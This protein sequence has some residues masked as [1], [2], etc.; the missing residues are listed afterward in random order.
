[1]RAAGFVEALLVAWPVIACIHN[2][3]NCAKTEHCI[4]RALSVQGAEPHRVG[5][6][7]P[8]FTR[9]LYRSASPGRGRSEGCACC[10]APS[11]PAWGGPVRPCTGAEWVCPPP[12]KIP[13]HDGADV[14]A[15]G[16]Y[17]P[18]SAASQ[19]PWKVLIELKTCAGFDE[20]QLA[21]TRDQGSCAHPGRG[22]GI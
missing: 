11:R 14:D 5:D 12:P 15:A 8:D 2:P 13:A 21:V 10:R 7:I 6:R 20:A 1:V 3:P 9:Q 22:Q 18:E 17:Y 4:S 16:E 19:Y